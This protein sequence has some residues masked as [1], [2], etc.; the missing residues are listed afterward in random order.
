MVQLDGII[1]N[2][3]SNLSLT[4]NTGISC[5]YFIYILYV[6]RGGA[7]DRFDRVMKKAYRFYDKP[8]KEETYA[9]DYN[10]TRMIVS[11]LE[12]FVKESVRTINWDA[13]KDQSGVDVIGTCREI[14]SDFR[15]YLDNIEECTLDQYKECEAKLKRGFS[16]LGDIVLHLGW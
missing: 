6:E 15:F 3:I 14:I 13:H 4:I 16:L 10:L 7:M 9:L 8:K 12:L 11:R 2:C 1:L 5:V